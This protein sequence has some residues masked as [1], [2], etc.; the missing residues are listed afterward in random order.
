MV[1]II[2]SYIY[3]RNLGCSVVSPLPFLMLDSFLSNLAG[4]NMN[5]FQASVNSGWVFSL[6]HPNVSSLLS[7]MDLPCAISNQ[8]L[9][10][11]PNR[12]RELCFCIAPLYCFTSQILATSFSLPSKICLLISVIWVFPS[13]VHY[14]PPGWKPR[15]LESLPHWF[16]FSRESQFCPTCCP[17]SVNSY[18]IYSVQFTSCLESW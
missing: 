17:T 6:Q 13:L 12:S 5:V 1:F 16:L 8:R 2:L 9:M 18:F 3:L 11:T 10:K 7:P 4:A 15:W 14:M